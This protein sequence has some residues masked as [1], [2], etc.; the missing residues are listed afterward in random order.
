MPTFKLSWRTRIRLRWEDLKRV[1]D[2]GAD[3]APLMGWP[4]AHRR[5]ASRG[6]RG[7]ASA[8]LDA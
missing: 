3:P 4:D 2:I 8:S 1:L 6:R 5:A 7:A